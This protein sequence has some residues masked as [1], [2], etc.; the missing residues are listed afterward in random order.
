MYF[1]RSL[2][3]VHDAALAIPV[4][5]PLPLPNSP[6]PVAN[7][8]VLR[9]ALHPTTVAAQKPTPGTIASL[10]HIKSNRPPHPS[11]SPPL[12]H[13]QIQPPSALLLLVTSPANPPHAQVPKQSSPILSASPSSAQPSRS[14]P[15]SHQ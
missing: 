12:E 15:Q 2:L 10:I 4:D 9:N 5:L 14:P 11:A 7:I 6:N 13:T 3:V 1:S 8:V